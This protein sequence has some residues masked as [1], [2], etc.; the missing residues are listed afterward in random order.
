MGQNQALNLDDSFAI[1]EALHKEAELTLTAD[2]RA[3]MD[4]TAVVKEVAEKTAEAPKRAVI[5]SRK[6][7]IP[8]QNVPIF[9]RISDLYEEADATRLL[10]EE[11]A[12]DKANI[13]P[14]NISPENAGDAPASLG[15][16]DKIIEDDFVI[17]AAFGVPEE[18]APQNVTEDEIALLSEAIEADSALSENT[19]SDDVTISDEIEPAVAL[20][21]V[22]EGLLPPEQ[23]TD[24][25]AEQTADQTA[26]PEQVVATAPLS[27]EAQALAALDATRP[28]A[29]EALTEQL[30][31]VKSAVEQAH[32]TP[33]TEMD[34]APEEMPEETP[35]ETAEDAPKEEDL[36]TL[37]AGPALATF[38]GETVREVLEEE[39]PHRVRGLVDEALGERQGRYGRSETPHIGLRTK[40]SRH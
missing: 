1:I 31:A 20:D 21:D 10:A 32:N 24:Q 18:D 28:E 33:Q 34:D 35:E 26:E 38:I 2:E 17:P 37:T 8:S 13:S 4:V 29:D 40:P 39:L 11:T 7:R 16:D 9:T 5:Q 19:P 14:E 36:S 3:R 6:P 12:R 22:L 25:T 23:T 30:E 15:A 27:E